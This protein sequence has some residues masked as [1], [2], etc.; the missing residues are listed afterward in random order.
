MYTYIYILLL[1]LIILLSILLLIS[2]KTISHFN[3]LEPVNKVVYCFWTG[4]NKLTSKRK[5]CLDS[6]IKNIG[7]PVILLTKKELDNYILPDY[8]LHEA[9][10]YLSEV[11]KADYLRTY[12]MHHYGG[13]Y[14]D[15]K[16]T[17]QDWNMYFDKLNNSDKWALGYQE[18][19]G[20]VASGNPKLYNA[21]KE[22][23]GNGSYIFRKNTSFTNEWINRLHNKL[24]EKLELLKLN[25]AIDYRDKH[26]RTLTDGSI[27][28]YPLAWAEILGSL[29]CEVNYKYRKHVLNDMIVINTSNY[30]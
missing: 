18:I 9:Y 7:V 3:I 13:G 2:V 21:Y 11:H 25:P 20:G 27:S 16:K 12:F 14:T 15:I 19:R 23:I 5:S 4:D 22:L 6:I 8:P 30:I 28:K 26:G 10:Q 24:D 1:I 29:F 17:T